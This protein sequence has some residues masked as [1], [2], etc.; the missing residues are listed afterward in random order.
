LLLNDALLL[1]SPLQQQAGKSLYYYAGVEAT[2]VQQVPWM[3][4]KR[5]TDMQEEILKPHKITDYNSEMVMS[6]KKKGIKL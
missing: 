2:A 6:K 5:H 4:N 1:L 3:V